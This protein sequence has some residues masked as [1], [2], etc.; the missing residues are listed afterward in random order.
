VCDVNHFV[1][2][3]QLGFV[4]YSFRL[5]VREGEGRYLIAIFILELHSPPFPKSAH[6]AKFCC[7]F[8]EHPGSLLFCFVVACNA[9]EHAWYF[10]V[11]PHRGM[12]RVD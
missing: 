2:P 10:F 3:G 11:H 5:V 12:Q 6:A 8:A 1:Q 4:K 9:I 7:H